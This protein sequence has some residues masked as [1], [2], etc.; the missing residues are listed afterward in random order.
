MAYSGLCTGL[1][2]RVNVKLMG[3]YILWALDSEEEDCARVACGLISDISSALEA[4]I[5][6]YLTSFV[7]ELLKVLKSPQ[8]QRVS[9][10]HA[11][12]SLSDLAIYCPIRYAEHYLKDTLVIL[13]QAGQISLT[14]VNIEEDP[15]LGEYM[16]ELRTNV[17]N[18]Y[19]TVIGA[20]KD[21]NLQNQVLAE[22]VGIMNF[23]QQCVQ[24]QYGYVS[25]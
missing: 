12:Q 21:S 17:I 19:T 20:A 22:I 10:L 1:G 11:L 5:E 9:K 4:N 23:L 8:R 25:F 16:Q 18:C 13:Q 3:Q 7:P 2:S 14:P 15:E 24:N 6:E